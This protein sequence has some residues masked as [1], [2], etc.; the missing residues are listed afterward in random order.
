[1]TDAKHTRNHVAALC[2]SLIVI[3]LIIVSLF[4]DKIPVPLCPFKS[5]TGLPCPGCGGLRAANALL[6]GNILGAIYTN[7]LS[8]VVILCIAILP[9]LYLYDN[10]AGKHLIRSLL[11]RTWNRWVTLMFSIVIISNWIWNIYKSL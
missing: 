9:L 7:P 3:L 8:C 1:M 10:I 2:Y 6:H 5:L 4:Y 11:M